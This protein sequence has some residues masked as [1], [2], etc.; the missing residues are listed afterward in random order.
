MRLWAP[1]STARSFSAAHFSLKLNF[2]FSFNLGTWLNVGKGDLDHPHLVVSLARKEIESSF[3]LSI[4]L[5]EAYTQES[6]IQGTHPFMSSNPGRKAVF[7]VE[8]KL[9]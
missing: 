2:G 3:V 6:A 1:D 7:F 8:G 4:E 5:G 9:D